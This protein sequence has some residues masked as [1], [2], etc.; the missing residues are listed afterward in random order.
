MKKIIVV[1]SATGNV[2]VKN[3]STY[4][5]DEIRRCLKTLEK[6]ANEPV[7]VS[8]LRAGDKIKMTTDKWF[9]VMPKGAKGT[10]LGKNKTKDWLYDIK[11]DGGKV[12]TV[13]GR[14]FD[15]CTSI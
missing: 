14:F 4:D 3:V 12:I 15:I 5:R 13:T 6:E 7:N 2:R 8:S 1:N 10:F 9:S 11:L